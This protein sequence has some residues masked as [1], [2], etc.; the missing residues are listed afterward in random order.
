MPKTTDLLDANE[1]LIEQG[2]L[3]IVS[4]IFHDYGGQI[5]FSGS[6]ATVKLKED[7]SLVRTLLSEPGQGRVLVIDGGGSL[8]TALCG[9]QLAAKAVENDWRG[10]VVYGAI[11]DA[12]EIAQLPLG[13]KALNTCPLKSRKRGLGERDIPVRFG[14]VT[15]HS[16]EWLY[17]DRDGII[18]SSVPILLQSESDRS[19]NE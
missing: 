2:L 7:N 15:F 19:E 5:E 11:R 16:G 4:P 3:R 9:D 10:L 6:I 18:V 1:T 8:S 14:E 13:V 17:A 12:A